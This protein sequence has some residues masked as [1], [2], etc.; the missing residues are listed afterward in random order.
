MRDLDAP[1][2]VC[3]F[4]FLIA[5]VYGAYNV[6]EKIYDEIVLPVWPTA[7]TGLPM[8]RWGSGIRCP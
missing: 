2:L 5:M 8:E 7:A 3:L 4:A 6:E 1:I